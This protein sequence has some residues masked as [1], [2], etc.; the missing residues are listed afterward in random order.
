VVI[1]GDSITAGHGLSADQAYPAVLQEKVDAEHLNYQVVNAG[2]SGDTTAGGLRRVDWALSAGAR[3]LIIALGGNDGLRGIP[4]KQ[5]EANLAGIIQKARAK[6]PDLQIVVA[7]MQ[8]PSSMG[9]E[10]ARTFGAVFPKV[11]GENK[12][13]LIPYLLK[14]VGG[15]DKMNQDDRIHPTVEG[16]RKIA[17]N[18]W[19]VLRGVLQR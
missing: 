8:M 19:E 17:D 16:Q 12:A 10:F 3:V 2:V 6:I 11:A 13:T 7:G 5:T 4:I 14:D 18:V 9:A 15:V 1:L